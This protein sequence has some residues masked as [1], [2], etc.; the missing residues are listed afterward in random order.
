[1][2]T[3]SDEAVEAQGFLA[4]KFGKTLMVILS[5]ILI[6]AGPTYIVYG[7][8]VILGLSLVPSFVV[9]FVLF[10]VGIVMMWYLVK[11]KIVS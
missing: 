1:M 5:V 9:G 7:L 3:D 11:Q 6:F 8:Y 10:A 4:S 2:T